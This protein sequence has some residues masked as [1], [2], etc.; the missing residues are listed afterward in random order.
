MIVEF[1]CSTIR[2]YVGNS[3]LV[4]PDVI[5]FWKFWIFSKAVLMV[6]ITVNFQYCRKYRLKKKKVKM[7]NELSRNTSYKLYVLKKCLDQSSSKRKI[8]YFLITMILK[9]STHSFFRFF[10]WFPGDN[11][12]LRG[13]SDLLNF[14]IWMFY[15]S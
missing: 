3:R 6:S 5:S 9:V 7:L 2:K 8:T 4:V 12:N 13:Q 1:R 15:A 11:K 10:E 14:K